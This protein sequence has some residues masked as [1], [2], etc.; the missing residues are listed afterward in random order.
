MLQEV[1][2]EDRGRD[3][4]DVRVGAGVSEGVLVTEVKALLCS[5]I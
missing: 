3:E 2:E 4:D 5:G 1:V